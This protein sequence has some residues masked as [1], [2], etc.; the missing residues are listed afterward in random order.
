M[1]DARPVL[2]LERITKSY[3]GTRALDAVSFRA[4]PG[5]IHALAGENGAGKSTLVKVMSGVVE[6]DEGEIRWDGSPVELASPTDAGRLGIHMVHQEL[7]LLDEL[8]VAD[9]VYLGS[10]LRGRGGMVDR[11]A[12]AAGAGRA[13]ARLDSGVSPTA[14]TGGLSTAGKQMVEVARG[15]VRDSRLLILDEP[16]AALS[17]RDSEG[18][19]RALRELA[20]G[21]H[22]IVYISHRLGEVLELCDEVTV[23][24]DGRFVDT[25]PAAELDV[26]ELVRLM[27]GRRVADLYPPK[28]AEPTGCTML[29]VSGLTD[30]PKV[31]GVDLA[32]EAG[33]VLGIYGL[34]GSGQDELLACLAGERRPLRGGLEIDGRPS[35]WRD[36]RG[37]VAH[38]VGYVPQDRKNE[39]LLLELPSS[40]NI[41]FPLLRGLARIGFVSPRRERE[42]AE[43]AAVS[44][45]VRGD[46]A[47]PAMTLSGGN[48]QKV[49]LARWIAAGARLFVLNQPTRGVDVGSKAEIYKLI[50]SLCEERGAAAIVTSPEIGE[51]LGL[52]D[53]VLVMH[54]GRIVGEAPMDAGEAR[55]LAMAVA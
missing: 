16:T 43:R 42:T 47:R 44:A 26:E 15:L 20:A 28:R 12:M 38:G 17:P 55:V 25:R 31:R 23:L 39:G 32:V 45:G 1:S 21:G 9:N 13:L 27:V 51:L 36:I 11:R 46:I 53:R 5:R 48:Q 49:V 41:A 24:K 8:T 29:Q 10:E 14:R 4:L 40:R 7:A 54:D 52:C 30:P 19:F 2:E 35:R 33:E 6:P 37:M 50:R 3:G 22:A 34:E 18:L